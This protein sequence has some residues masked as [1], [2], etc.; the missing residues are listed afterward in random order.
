MK[1]NSWF[2]RFLAGLGIGT[3]AAIPGVSGAAIALIF[4]VYE[5]IINAVNNFRKEAKK[6]IRT[7][8]PILIGILIAVVVCVIVFKLAFEHIMFLLI[9]IF[10]GF[11]IGSIPSVTDEVKCESIVPKRVIIAIASGVI[12][13]G[14]G[15]LSIVLGNKG[16]S[17]GQYF[18]NGLLNNWWMFFILF[19]V[20]IIASVALTIPG[21]SGSLILLVLGFYRPLIDSASKWG[22]EMFQGLFDNTLSL[23]LMILTFG[24]GCLV[25]VVIVSKAMRKLLDNHHA[26]TYYAI[27]GFIFGSIPVLFLNYQ[28]WQYYQ[29]WG[30]STI[31]GINPSMNM[32]AE[33]ILGIIILAICAFFS[34]MIV[35]M[36]RNL[37][38]KEN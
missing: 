24:L 19:A 29:V 2:K 35:R 30:G 37:K 4:R 22:K 1:K 36:Q 32:T 21:F 38:N 23:V 6:S 34:Y 10:A 28:I 13:I 17:V 15:V 20:G 25:G 27:I 16:F 12:V 11:L 7:L 9:C 5:D 31:E 33:I 8:L 26:S 18:E 14:L 3:G